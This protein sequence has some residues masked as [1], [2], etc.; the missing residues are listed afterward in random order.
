M[1]LNNMREFG[2]E[3][4]DAINENEFIIFLDIDG[5]LVSYD[6]LKE[7]NSKDGKQVFV[8]EAV[9][10]LNTIINYYNASLCMI[11]GWN[12]NFQGNCERYTDFLKGRGIIV[13]NLT[14]GDRI[15]RYKFVEDCIKQYPNLKYLII[16]DEYF[17]Y[18]DSGV[19]PHKRILG[20]NMYRC[21][22]RYDAKWA[23]YNFKLDI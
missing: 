7:R 19:I 14:V 10:A 21:L 15:N 2:Q 4:I 17:G 23:T 1:T 22:D 11:S 13:N 5:V 6:N 18:Y 20:T 16:D 8:Q 12:A 3:A 9:D